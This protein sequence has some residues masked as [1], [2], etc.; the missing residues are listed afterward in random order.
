MALSTLVVFLYGAQ[1]KLKDLLQGFSILWGQLLSVTT[2]TLTFFLN[3]SYGLWRKCYDY[4]RRLQG[5]LNDLGLTLAA[6]AT[7][8][9]P[10]S[11]DVPSTYTPR[12]RQVLELVSRYVR[13]FNL[14]TYA[15][16]TRSHRPILTP[17]GMRRLVE[18]GIL[19]N[20]ER[21][22][23]SEADVP[24]TQRHNAVLV[25]LTRLF[26]EGTQTGVFEGGT[27]FEQQFMEKIH[28]IRAQY[29]AI[30]DELQGRMPLAYAHIVQVLL[31]VVLWMYPFMAL[32][33][34]MAWHLC[35]AGTFLLTMFYQG[36]FDLAKQFLDPY[37]NEN[38]GQGDDPLVIDTL[39]AETNA[40][41]IRWMNSFHAQPWN[42]QQ[43]DDGEL[44]DSILP[45]MG[46][47]VKDLA[48]MEAQEEKERQ[49]RELAKMEKQR[50][51]EDKER[52]KAE[53]LLENLV[54]NNQN[55]TSLVSG[56]RYNGTAILTPVGE[57]LADSDADG[58]LFPKTL[59]EVSDGEVKEMLSLVPPSEFASISEAVVAEDGLAVDLNETS[60]EVV[61]VL[62]LADGTIVTHDEEDLVIN[63][64]VTTT[65]ES[66]TA[67]VEVNSTVEDVASTFAE[68]AEDAVNGNGLPR[69]LDGQ[70]E[71]D[72]DKLG[73]TPNFEES[74][75]EMQ[76]FRENSAPVGLYKSIEEV[77]SG[78][79]DDDADED[80]TLEPWAVEWFDELGPDGQEYRLSQMLADEDWSDELEE[81][82]DEDG[83]N[84]TMTLEQYTKETKEL[85]ATAKTELA[86]EKEVLQYS[87]WNP[88][89]MGDQRDN[90]GRKKTDA[91]IT[92]QQL[93]KA[94]RDE[95]TDP[96]YDQ[97]RLDAI[98]QLWGAHPEVLEG[99]FVDK[100][101]ELEQQTNEISFS[102]VYSLWGEGVPSADSLDDDESINI[103]A[104]PIDSVTQ[105]WQQT[106]I[107]HDD[108]DNDNEEL[109]VSAYANFEWW[110]QV[111]EDGGSL[112]L[113]QMLADEEWVDE[114]SQEDEI[115]SPT[116]T[117]EQFAE[118]TEKMIEK[119]EDEMKETEAI[120]A[121]QPNAYS[122][123]T[124]DEDDE[125]RDNK[126]KEEIFETVAASDEFTEMVKQ[127]S[128]DVE[129]AEILDGDMRKNI[130]SDTIS[131]A[132][133]DFLE[134]DEEDD[135][136]GAQIDVNRTSALGGSSLFG[137]KSETTEANGPL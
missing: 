2:F 81:E 78:L 130:I 10:S 120:M 37:D 8:T 59:L 124:D 93:R 36:L 137:E 7:R 55:G 70:V 121:A 61:K 12:S 28:V 133:I 77:E 23:L 86:E 82:A 44:Y 71:V 119:F 94:E 21:E 22:I 19:T 67:S 26:L 89:Q 72:W 46:Y 33:T 32:S 18:R 43:L 97:T 27:G 116:M 118:E 63:K 48:E 39:I 117:Y 75:A 31:D 9:K 25:W 16:F 53:K 134:M 49:E 135:D 20:K 106:G 113:S 35:I 58:Y 6:H 57:V 80:D 85:I 50:E 62:T 64:T 76:T 65:V 88:A 56:E 79:G 105:L 131:D 129:V 126:S 84:L 54:A 29:G 114:E 122:L 136:A 111:T 5:R 45:P 15:S 123:E 99:T 68:V 30:G 92:S 115:E 132:E 103:A 125:K 73:T 98:S 69:L 96:L 95:E 100:E 40:G 112:R 104:P 47:S 127:L 51:K 1:P 108:I 128:D 74:I 52:I 38:F 3:Q 42:K 110:D 91:T 102:N 4:S 17:R 24:A 83:L 107:D 11:S 34:G 41:S 101:E 87:R 66:R 60:D 90:G 14:L 13:V 109:D